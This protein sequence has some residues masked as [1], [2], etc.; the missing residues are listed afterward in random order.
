M[1]PKFFLM[2]GPKANLKISAPKAKLKELKPELN[3]APGPRL[4]DGGGSR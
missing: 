3:W 2:T 1:G 4:E